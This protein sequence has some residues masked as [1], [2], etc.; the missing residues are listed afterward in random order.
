M[1]G[2][3]CAVVCYGDGGRALM[4]SAFFFPLVGGQRWGQFVFGDVSRRDSGSRGR[5]RSRIS[6]VVIFALRGLVF[7][8]ELL[9]SGPLHLCDRHFRLPLRSMWFLFLFGLSVRNMQVSV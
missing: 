1:Y 3:A 8:D 7:R 2:G 4:V 6:T 9:S 5:S